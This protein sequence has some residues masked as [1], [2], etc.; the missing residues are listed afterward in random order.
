MSSLSLGTRVVE[1]LSIITGNIDSKRAA[2][3]DF[4]ESNTRDGVQ[5]VSVSLPI[6]LDTQLFIEKGMKLHGGKSRIYLQG[7][8]RKI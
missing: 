7:T 3:K 4:I 8:S 2:S 1:K 6:Y 5:Q